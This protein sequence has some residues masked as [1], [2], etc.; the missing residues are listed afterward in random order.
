MLVSW[1]RWIIWV[2]ESNP[3]FFHALV[4]L[5]AVIHR[6][7]YLIPCATT[8]CANKREGDYC[9]KDFQNMAIRCVDQLKLGI[10]FANT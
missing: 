2:A 6:L 1:V 10:R 3:G 7:T 8:H 4:R 9:V 5:S